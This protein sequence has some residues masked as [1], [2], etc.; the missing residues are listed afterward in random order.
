LSDAVPSVTTERVVHVPS[1]NGTFDARYNRRQFLA[2]GIGA[3]LAVALL[4]T[5][6]S[7][8]VLPPKLIPT[9]VGDP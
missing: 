4:P 7:A 3:A 1:S 8:S 9:S 6:K 2:I 5:F